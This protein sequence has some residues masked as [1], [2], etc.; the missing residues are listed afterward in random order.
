MLNNTCRYPLN[1]FITSRTHFRYFTLDD[2]RA[3]LKRRRFENCLFV[4]LRWVDQDGD[5]CEW[6]LHVMRTFLSFYHVLHLKSITSWYLWKVIR[7]VTRIFS[8]LWTHFLHEN[9]FWRLQGLKTKVSKC[10]LLLGRTRFEITVIPSTLSQITV[11][12]ST[13]IKIMDFR[14][15]RV[16]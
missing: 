10:L 8:N 5:T 11:A 3:C 4:N 13:S 12:P 7:V 2:I 9:L 15:R 1:T 14:L 16:L 6:I